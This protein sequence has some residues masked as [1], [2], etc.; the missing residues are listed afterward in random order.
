M[1]RLTHIFLRPDHAAGYCHI[2][3]FIDF[4][5]VLRHSTP[6][7]PSFLSLILLIPYHCL[8]SGAPDGLFSAHF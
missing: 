2:G 4:V 1:R 6:N 8:V 7:D 5:T 3:L